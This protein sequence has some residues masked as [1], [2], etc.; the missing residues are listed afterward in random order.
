[1]RAWVNQD[2]SGKPVLQHREPKSQGNPWCP[3]VGQIQLSPGP[4]QTPS[5]SP[6]AIPRLFQ[7]H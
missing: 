3:G 4:W 1:M 2:G 6:L 5:R 7:G